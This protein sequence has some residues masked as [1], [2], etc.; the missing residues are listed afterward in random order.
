MIFGDEAA[1]DAVPD[2][3]AILEQ[4]VRHDPEGISSLYDRYSGV[5][6]AL[7]YHLLRDRAA[8]EDVVQ[9]AFLT[10][11]RRAC[12]G[13][14]RRGTVRVWLLTVVHHQAINVLRGLWVQGG[15]PMDSEHIPPFVGD[16]DIAA[17]T[18]RGLDRE[19]VRAAFATLPS[20]QQQIVVLAYFGGLTHHE[21]SACA[22]IP[23]GT[24]KGRMCLALE[25]LRIALR[26]RGLTRLQT[27]D[28]WTAIAP[29]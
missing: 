10:V 8:A 27:G 16:A 20:D 3:D 23:L 11:W 9:R 19:Q 4:I 26:Q 12:T 18:E 2:D 29:D 13:D 17:M 5:A 28:V 7:A 14:A 21:I 15:M 6:F 22:A 25:N 24:V 1:P